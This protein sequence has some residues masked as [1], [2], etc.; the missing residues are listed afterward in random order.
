M[1]AAAHSGAATVATTTDHLIDSQLAGEELAAAARKA[2]DWAGEAF[3]HTDEDAEEVLA[4]GTARRRALDEA[5]SRD[6]GRAG[7]PRR[8]PGR[9]STG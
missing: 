8:T 5:L 4:P 9:S 3:L 6:R 2:Q 1:E 7:A